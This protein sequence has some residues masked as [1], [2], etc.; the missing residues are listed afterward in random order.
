MLKLNA[1]PI[2]LC[3][4]DVIGVYIE[5]HFPGVGYQHENEI[6]VKWVSD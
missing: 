5:F 3:C 4:F 6:W 2:H 1:T